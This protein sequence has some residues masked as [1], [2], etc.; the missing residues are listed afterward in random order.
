MMKLQRSLACMIAALLI[1]PASQAEDLLQI[2]QAAL[3][4]DPVLS[5]QESALE[6]TSQSQ[7]QTRA[8]YFPNIA[9]SADVSRNSQDTISSSFGSTGKKD[10]NNRGY[11]LSLRQPLYRW[12]YI[13]QLRQAK[14]GTRQAEAELNQAY[15]EIILRVAQA[16]FDVLAARDGVDFAM[17]EK[18]AISRQLDQA[19][20][21]FD[22]GLIAIT[23]VHEAQAAYDQ[24]VASEIVA[25]NAMA[26]SRLTLRELTGELPEKLAGLSDKM[27]L[28][29]PEPDNLEEWVNS[30]LQNNFKLLAAEAA[31]DAAR[32]GVSVQRAGHHPTLDLVAGYNYNDSGGTFSSETK[33]TSVGVQLNIPLYQGGGTTA[34]VRSATARLS[35]AKDNLEQQRRATQREANDAYLAVLAG[36]SQVKALQQA[37]VSSQSALSATKAGYDVVNARRELFRTERDYARAR[38]DYILAS[39]RLKQA[40]GM[41]SIK[42]VEQINA[43]LTGK[44]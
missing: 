8:L 44:A 24:S 26:S 27:K 43:W 12:D 29:S 2:Y 11:G 5:A 25:Q 16:Y 20:Q 28:A 17:A 9:L 38:Y 34:A 39:L 3:K 22:V 15:Q 21:R 14:A 35:Q 42:D 13:S 6:A 41:L 31:T 10:F 32:Q 36:I 33:S 18:N 40:A 37:V 19:K 1:S 7:R 4:S 30:A 23:D